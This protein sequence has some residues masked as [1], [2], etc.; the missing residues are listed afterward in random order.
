MSSK[1]N[2]RGVSADKEDVHA[3]IKGLDKGLYPTAF[4][5]ILPDFAGNDPEYC[6]IMHADTAGTKTSLAYMYW[7]ETGDM[8]VWKG[9]VQDAIVM[10]TDDMA[11]VGCADRIILSSTIGRNKALIGKEVISALIKATTGFI[12]QMKALD[13]EIILAG[14]ETADVGDI[15][16]TADV[17]F[18]AF[19]RLKKSDLVIN[20]IRPG[21]VI[22]G[23]ASYGKAI[24][25]DEYNSGIGS[26]GL[27][28]ARHEL[29]GS[30][31]SDKYPETYAPQTDRDYVYTGGH[32]LTDEVKIQNETYTVGKL[33]LSP[34]RT[35]LPVLKKILNNHRTAIHGIIH[36]T[37]GGHSKVLRYCDEPVHIV[38]DNLLPVP[39]VFEVIKNSADTEWEEMFKVFNMGT[40]LEFYTDEAT[41]A[42]IIDISKS[43][44]IDAAVIG[45]VEES[46]QQSLSVSLNYQGNKYLYS[47]D[48]K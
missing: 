46:E 32:A 15:V 11:C 9:I 47:L 8:S 25:E 37:G 12:E 36:N 45:R 29:F 23:L 34:T 16:R 3:A 1:Y 7:K 4:C 14:G 38:K 33:A 31:Y 39:P 10:N 27:T 28:M 26:N 18:T 6:N 2:L 41:A 17:G 42:S 19:S 30:S 13:V 48:G 35:F 21:Q 20:K 22:V 5:K 24:Y 44:H 43:F 40:R